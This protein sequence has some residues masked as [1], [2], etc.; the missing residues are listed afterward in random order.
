MRSNGSE[1]LMTVDCTDF[2]I[3]EPQPWE[4]LWFSHKFNGPGL[5]YKMGVCI[6]TGWIVWINGPFPCGDFPD[7]EI[8][9]LSLAETLPA[10][11]LVETDEGYSGD[12]VRKPSD[13]EGRLEWRRMKKNAMARHETLNGRLKQ[14]N[15]LKARYRGDRNKHFLIV[16]ACACIIQ[17]E[18]MERRAVFNVEY[19]II[20]ETTW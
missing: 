6:Q 13:Y 7:L 17:S 1:C 5:R 18:I 9:Q 10:G 12:H 16:N 15:I 20:R 2:L 4:P 8:F 14:F 19:K 11:E 3:N